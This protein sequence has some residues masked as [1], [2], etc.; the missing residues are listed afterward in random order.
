MSAPRCS[1]DEGRLRIEW[2]ERAVELDGGMLR[3]HCRC[4]GCRSLQLQG[5]VADAEDISVSGFA[6][7]GYG[8]QL[9][10]SDGHDRGVF[11]WTYLAEIADGAHRES[12]RNSESILD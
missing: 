3:R 6:A 5:R 7:M 10:F 1:I 9:C 11:P 4:A 2:P 8:V 12:N